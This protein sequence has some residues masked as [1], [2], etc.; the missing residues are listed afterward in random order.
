MSK[1]IK[2]N[3][4]DEPKKLTPRSTRTRAITPVKQQTPETLKPK[5]TPTNSRPPVQK[6]NESRQFIS[7]TINTCLSNPRPRQ[8]VNQQPTPSPRGC[9]P[10][11]TSN[12]ATLTPKTFDSDLDNTL[13]EY[14]PMPKKNSKQ[15]HSIITLDDSEDSGSLT[16]D[17]SSSDRKSTST[18]IV[19]CQVGK[20]TQNFNRLNIRTEAISVETAKKTRTRKAS[21]PKPVV[22]VTGY[23]H[24]LMLQLDN[25]LNLT[26]T[27]DIMVS[28][29]FEC[30]GES[31]VQ[32]GQSEWRE[33]HIKSAFNYVLID[34]RISRNLPLRA[35]QGMEPMEVLRVFVESIFYI[36]KGSR[37]RPY[38]HLHDTLKVWKANTRVSLSSEKIPKKVMHLLCSRG[39]K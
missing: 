36:G 12:S 9:H 8:L 27:S 1:I 32:S 39:L 31:P 25:R 34:P 10:S 16:D 38:A 23:S 15:Q 33:G 24:E 17:L 35:K 19:E 20:L 6:E 28:N 3:Q 22:V 4:D 7:G 26:T 11:F 29:M 14:C 5:K 30:F 37:A 13:E 21:E 2:Q 18:K